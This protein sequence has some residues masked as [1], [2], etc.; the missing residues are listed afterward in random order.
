MRST[1]L[2]GLAGCLLAGA[3]GGLATPANAA[4]FTLKF[5]LVTRGDM[6]NV[7]A[8]KLKEVLEAKSKGRIEVKVFPASQLGTPQAQIEGLQL[9]T[10]EA[11]MVPSDFF[12]GVDSRFGVFSIPLLFKSREH[13]AA[14]VADAELNKYILDIGEAKGLVGGGVANAAD[15][16]Y[17]AKKPITKLDDFKGMKLRV[18]ATPAERERMKRFGA[19]AVPMPLSEMLTSLQSG[20][21]DGTMSGISIYTNFNLHTIGT[22]LTETQDTMLVC[23]AALSKKWLDTLPP[24]LRTMVIEESRGLQKFAAE[25]GI[26]ENKTLAARWA[27]RGGTIIKFSDADMVELRKRLETVGDDVTKADANANAFYQR[28]KAVAAKY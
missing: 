22:V 12:V 16:K 11:F 2:G 8:D 15:A 7:Y 6:Q 20:V 21:I 23:F 18:N 19:T 3:L 14:T 10:I 28:V 1:T 25:Q 26:N 5:G 4:D 9:G 17:F 24:D 13:T 27:E